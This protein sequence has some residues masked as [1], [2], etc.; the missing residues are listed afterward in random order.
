MQI[1]IDGKIN[2]QELKVISSMLVAYFAK[3][4]IEGFIAVDLD[5]KPFSQH[6]NLPITLT[7]QN[8]LIAC[9]EVKRDSSGEFF[10]EEITRDTAE[11]HGSWGTQPF[12]Q[13]FKYAWGWYVAAA[14]ITLVMLAWKSGWLIFKFG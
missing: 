7:K 8:K 4:H 12:E 2:A 11:A 13:Q 5:L 9:L 1:T 3:Y 10:I 14:L 6:T